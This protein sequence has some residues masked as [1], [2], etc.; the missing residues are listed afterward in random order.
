MAA[1]IMILAGGTGGHIFPAL[2]VARELLDRGNEVIWMGSKAGME[3][4]VVPEAGIPLRQLAVSGFRGKGLLAKLAAPFRLTR[5]C[6]QAAQILVTDRPSVV[7]GMGGFVAGPGGFM[8][9]LFG[10]PLV[11]H[12]QN[13]IPGTTNRIL[14]KFAALVLEAFPRS[15]PDSA[16]A[17]C[18]GNPLRREIGK[19]VPE[20]KARTG[21]KLKVL[22][23]GGSQGAQALNELVPEA[24]ALCGR[25]V[26]VLHQTGAAMREETEAH[27][28]RLGADEARVVPFIEDMA[29]AYDWADLAICRAGAMTVSELTAA[30]LPAV[31]VPFPFAIDDHQTA[32]AR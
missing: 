31:L 10:I 12:E 23:V 27:Y 29:E 11:I 13:R 19:A 21:E 26:S 6:L 1:R 16:N 8:A 15:F 22:V 2:A 5:A 30:G 28:R 9:R 25:A 3:T 14:V 32:N 18:V 17:R 20:E 7:L 4:R 24:I